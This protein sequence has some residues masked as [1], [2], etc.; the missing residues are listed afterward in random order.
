LIG[1]FHSQ[2]GKPETLTLKWH[3]TPLLVAVSMAFEM[4]FI[5]GV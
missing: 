4:H 1:K 3:V 5:H 2:Q